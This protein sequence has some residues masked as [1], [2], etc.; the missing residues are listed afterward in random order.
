MKAEDPSYEYFMLAFKLCLKKHSAKVIAIDA[1]VSEA[2]L[3]QIK[4]KKRAAGFQGQIKI[5]NACGYD[6]IDFI[7][8][9]K[10]LL[11]ANKKE[12]RKNKK[13]DTK[14]DSSS[15]ELLQVYKQQLKELK[16]QY[17]ESKQERQ[18]LMQDC[19]DLI[20]DLREQRK[21]T[22]RLYKENTQLSKQLG[23]ANQALNKLKGQQ[24]GGL[25]PAAN[26]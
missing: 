1:E 6:Y 2:Y 12:S 22:D 8:L 18:K 20:Q 21:T 14:K 25:D 19:Q 11:D 5:A 13:S 17:Q 23:E 24:S 7:Q 3:S 16:V 4:R 9:G 10:N 15:D 26:E